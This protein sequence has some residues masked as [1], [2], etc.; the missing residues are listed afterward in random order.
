MKKSLALAFGFSMALFS[1]NVF[2]YGVGISTFP[3]M[4]DKKFLT[5]EFTGIMNEGG[6]VGLQARYSQKMNHALMLEAGAGLGGGE[7]SNRFFVGADYELFPDYMNQPRISMKTSLSNA[8]EFDV[9]RNVLSVAPTISKGFS[10]WGEEAYPFLSIPMGLSLE[11]GSKTYETV[12]A[13]SMGITGH[14]P[15][16]GYREWTGNLEGTVNLRN[17]YSG[18]FFGISYPIN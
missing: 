7:R 14:L 17:S 5:T 10:F 4:T 13:M 15:I 3:M 12:A 1:S 16:D 8:R 2:A 6:G 11:S 18:I 9:R